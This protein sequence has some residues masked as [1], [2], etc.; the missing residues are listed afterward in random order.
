MLSMIFASRYV[1]GAVA[2]GIFAYPWIMSQIAI[3][4]NLADTLAAVAPLA[5]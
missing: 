1:L 2:V 5:N 4:Q 3:F